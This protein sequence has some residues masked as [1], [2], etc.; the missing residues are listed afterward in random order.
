[1]SVEGLACL[2][3]VLA[4]AVLVAR[5]AVTMEPGPIAELAALCGLVCV[6]LAVGLLV[7]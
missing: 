5:G 6:A 3:L 1:M 4:G 2:G 7:R